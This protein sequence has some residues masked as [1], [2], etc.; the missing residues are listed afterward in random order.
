M[1]TKKAPTIEQLRARSD[2]DYYLASDVEI[3]L[4][5]KVSSLSKWRK[6][7]IE[8]KERIGPVWHDYEG[9]IRY[10]VIDVK[11]YENERRCA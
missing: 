3:L 5:V 1:T 7:W 11:N 8:H 6:R 9:Q 10:R 2:D 4:R